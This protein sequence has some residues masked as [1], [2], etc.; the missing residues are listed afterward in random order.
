[1]KSFIDLSR[2]QTYNL[3]TLLIPLKGHWKCARRPHV[4]QFLAKQTHFKNRRVSLMKL[5]GQLQWTDYLNSQLL[6]MQPNWVVRIMLYGVYSVLVF[7]FVSGLYF[8]AVGQLD[9]QLSYILPLFFFIAFYPLYRYVFLPNRVKKIFTQ[10]KE[11]N[12]PFEIEFT[13]D[14]MIAS[15]EFGNSTRPWKNFTKWKENNE[16]IM[17]Y[18]SDV[19]YSILPKRI[20]TDSQ[21][22]ETV[23]SYLEK[24]KVP[25]AKSRS[26]ASCVIYIALVIVIGWIMYIN[27]RNSVVP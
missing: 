7:A 13:D 10:Q 8:F 26:M 3:I 25:A 9:T 17:V 4:S 20:F 1:M 21:Q 18:H 12:S 23:K 27:F 6:H 5:K 11:L 15:N 16:L 14:A 19:M 22:I 24:Y 2:P